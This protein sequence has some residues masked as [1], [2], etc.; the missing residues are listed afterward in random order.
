MSKRK[1]RFLASIPCD[2]IETSELFK[3]TKINLKYF[4]SS[5]AYS[6]ALE[7]LTHEELLKIFNKLISFSDKSLVDWSRENAGGGGLTVYSRYGDFPKNSDFTHPKHV[8]HDVQWCRFR[9]GNKFRLI[10]FVISDDLHGKRK[11]P[12]DFI[13]DKNT[14]YLVF[15]DKEHKFYKTEP[16]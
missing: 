16:N 10:G 12:G 14:F 5:Q 15:V 2:S 7:D 9:L 8:P 6:S 4:E 1:E 11:D 13:Y 3:L